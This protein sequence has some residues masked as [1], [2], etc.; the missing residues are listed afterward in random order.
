MFQGRILKYRNI[1]AQSWRMSSN[2]GGQDTQKGDS[3]C[4]GL[5]SIAQG[6]TYLE[7]FSISSASYG[8]GWGGLNQVRYV[9][10]PYHTSTPPSAHS[11]LFTPPLGLITKAHLSTSPE[12]ILPTNS[13]LGSVFSRNQTYNIIT[14][15][16]CDDTTWKISFMCT[17]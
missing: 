16:V 12:N 2:L 1:W 8:L 7:G 4:K 15:A 13:F 6:G 3:K 11:S 17:M 5:D 9:W 10:Q 14:D